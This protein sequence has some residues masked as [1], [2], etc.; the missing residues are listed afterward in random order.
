MLKELALLVA[1]L[2]FITDARPYLNGEVRIRFLIRD[3]ARSFSL[4]LE[5]EVDTAEIMNDDAAEMDDGGEN[6]KNDA[7][8]DDDK[9]LEG[10]IPWLHTELHVYTHL[11]VILFQD[12]ISFLRVKNANV[13]QANEKAKVR[14]D[15]HNA[16]RL[17]LLFVYDG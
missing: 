2:A 3:C 16:M 9:L 8:G 10:K 6:G 7:Q 1:L 13:M 15:E 12:M 14:N 5:N 4:Q 11:H 17:L